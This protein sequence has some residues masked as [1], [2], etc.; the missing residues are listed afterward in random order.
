M[1]IG[2]NSDVVNLSIANSDG[3]PP[4]AP[5][6]TLGKVI[7][8]TATYNAAQH[9]VSIAWDAVP[10]AATYVLEFSEDGLNAFQSIGTFMTTTYSTRIA[11]TGCPFVF[12]KIYQIRCHAEAP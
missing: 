5:A 11:T 2:Q 3:T 9:G 7:N 4:A 10:N 12:G 8:L 6:P 1:L